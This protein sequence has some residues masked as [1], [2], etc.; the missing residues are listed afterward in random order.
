LPSIAKDVYMVS[1]QQEYKNM[2]DIIFNILSLGLKPLYEKNLSYYKMI[3]EFRE[4]LPRRQNEARKLSEAEKKNSPVL[5]SLQHFTVVDLSTHK[6][7]LNEADLD[8]FYN[9]LESFDYSFMFFKN[10]YKRYTRNLNRFNPKAQHK[11]FDLVMLQNVIKD[12]PIHPLKPFDVLIYHLK[13]KFKFTSKIYIWFLD[14]RK[15]I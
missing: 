9:K 11:N 14:R 2:L 15:K 7:S 3:R 12:D 8:M 13:W 4:K 1:G 6:T 10:Y 5:S